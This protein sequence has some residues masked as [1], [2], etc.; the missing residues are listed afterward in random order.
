[1]TKSLNDK[2]LGLP[3]MVGVDRLDCFKHLVDR[4]CA[5][6]AGWKEKLLPY[7]GKALIKAIAQVVP[8]FAMTVFKIPKQV[9]K[10]IHDAIARYWWGDDQFKK[11]MRWMAC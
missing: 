4:V 3:S 1:M 8:V 7:G 6:I 9:L 11:Q 5:L 10:G 2:Y